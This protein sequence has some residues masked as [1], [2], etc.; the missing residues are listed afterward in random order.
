MEHDRTGNNERSCRLTG[1]HDYLISKIPWRQTGN[2]R[3][4]TLPAIKDQRYNRSSMTYFE[5]NLLSDEDKLKEVWTNGVLIAERETGLFKYGLFQVEDYY[6]EQV[7][8]N[9]RTHSKITRTFKSTSYLDPY[10]SDIDISKIVRFWIKQ[11][12]HTTI[13]YLIIFDSPSES[14]DSC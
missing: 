2:L 10:L 4:R 7:C 6:A 8:N 3:Q 1:W 13:P 9:F 12:C 11:P 14:F 5:F